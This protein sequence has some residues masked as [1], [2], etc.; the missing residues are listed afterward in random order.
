MA[1]DGPFA[2]QAEA[3]IASYDW[4]DIAS[5]EGIIVFYGASSTDNTTLTYYMIK[6]E[7]YS[8]T[9][10]TAGAGTGTGTEKALDLDFDM[11]SFNSPRTV[12][13]KLRCVVPLQI[14]ITTSANKGGIAYAI[15]KVRKWDGTTETE[16]TSNTKSRNSLP[17]GSTATTFDVVSFE[18]EVPQTNFKIGEVL[19]LTVEIWVTG[20]GANGTAVSLYHDP[21]NRGVTA[22]I[23]TQQLEFQV[24]FKINL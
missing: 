1:F 14:G 2:Q 8:D 5:G 9:S 11:S 20:Q 3:A 24:P 13:G 23:L 4:T 17:A 21:K 22:A 18:L 15:L 16:I 10:S 19:R 12:K 7:I 6:N